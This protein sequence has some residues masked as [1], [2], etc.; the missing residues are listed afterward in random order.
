MAPPSS[1]ISADL[2]KSKNAEAHIIHAEACNANLEGLQALVEFQQVPL[3]DAV[4][5]YQRYVADIPFV[6]EK[7]SR[8]R[9]SVGARR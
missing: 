6:A 5:L 8:T 3:E 7:S 4:K 2:S 9:K 1:A